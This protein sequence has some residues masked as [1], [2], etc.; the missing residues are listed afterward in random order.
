M[1][2][3]KASGPN[4]IPAGF[5]QHYWDIVGPKVMKDVLEFLR[6]GH[7]REL[8]NHTHIVLIPKIPNPNKTSDF[9][10]ISLCNVFYKIVAK[11]LVN[12]MR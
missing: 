11:L 12:R 10:P 1:S 2:K 8:W 3:W 7:T 6:D 4:G 5:F 9:Q